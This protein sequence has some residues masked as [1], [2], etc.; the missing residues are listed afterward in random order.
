MTQATE[1]HFEIGTASGKPFRLPADAITMSAGIFG[2]RGSGKSHTAS[3]EVEEVLDAG[4]PVIVIDPTD[5]WWG[6]RSSR[7]GKGRGDGIGRIGRNL[8][9]VRLAPADVWSDRG[10]DGAEGQRRLV[11]LRTRK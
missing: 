1:C 2:I 6:L 10:D 5:A 7:D 8:L 11:Q 3:V 4:Y 9:D